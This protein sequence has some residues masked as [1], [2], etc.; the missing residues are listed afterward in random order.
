M[1]YWRFVN[2]PQVTT[3]QLIEGWSRQTATVAGGRHALAIQDTSEVKFRTRQGCERGLGQVGKGN[4]RG[5]L[6]HA[7]MAV[8]AD[9]GACL[10]LA[11][12]KVWTRRGKV[13]SPHDQRELADKESARWVTTAEQGCEVLAAARMIT[14]INDREG[15][16]FAHWALTPGDN[17]HLLTRAMN[18]HA[19]TDGRTL[20]QAVEQAR[21]CD[22]AV[23]DL[24]RRMDRQGRRARLSLRLGTVAIKRPARPGVK[25]LP[26][27]VE[28]SFVEVVEL[29]PPK[30]AERIH[31]LLLTTHSVANAADAWRIVSWYKQRWIIE[32]LFRSLK[33][34]G[35]R[36]EDSQLESAEALIKLV[37]IATKVACIVIQLVQARNGGEQLPVECAFTREEI[38][39]LAAINQT[40][41]GRTELQKTPH[42]PHTLEW[43]A[44]IIA[45]LGGWTGYASHRPPGPITFHN[46]MAR[47]QTIVAARAIGNV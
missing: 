32:Q 27:S 18:D 44:W 10:G 15:E 38:E 11:G 36:V 35:L 43:A 29:H 23:I 46:G 31:W 7:M 21:F 26:E 2:N 19:L 3:D 9:S 34:Q 12:G 47:F 33:N 45:K 1:A 17:V 40:M 5:V 20:Y 13:K 28:V 6:L 37:A 39:A 41:K 4:A 30:G 16:F 22:K 25:G 8:D 42:H 14:V 24:P